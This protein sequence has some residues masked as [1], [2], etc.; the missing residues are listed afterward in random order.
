MNYWQQILEQVRKPRGLTELAPPRKADHTG[1]CVNILER[2]EDGRLERRTLEQIRG[3]L[4][5][6]KVCCW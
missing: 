1:S 5:I 6:N 4:A 3:N 2:K